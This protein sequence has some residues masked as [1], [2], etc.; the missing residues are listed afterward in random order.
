MVQDRTIVTMRDKWEVAYALSIGTK[1]I[2][3]KWRWTAKTHSVAEKMRLLEPTAQMWM[4]MEQQ[5]CK[6][7]TSFWKCKVYADIRGGSSWRGLQVRVMGN[8]WRFEWLL[9]RK[10]QR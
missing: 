1:I 2:D 8:F 3:L 5:Q 9:L 6:L 4:K 7:M 10:L